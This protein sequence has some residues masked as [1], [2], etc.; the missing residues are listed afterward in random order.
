[1]SLVGSMKVSSTA[2]LLFD[3]SLVPKK[4]MS[5]VHCK[6]WV[7]TYWTKVERELREVI[8]HTALCEFMPELK[9]AVSGTCAA[10]CH[11]HLSLCKGCSIQ[12]I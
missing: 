5:V 7:M 11:L 9:Q 10:F 3:L 2:S 12:V 1:M 4:H 6:G 8:A